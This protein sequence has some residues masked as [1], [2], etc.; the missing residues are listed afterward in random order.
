LNSEDWETI[1]GYDE[2]VFARTTPEPISQLFDGIWLGLSVINANLASDSS[3]RQAEVA[4]NLLEG[5]NL[6]SLNSEDWETICG[7]DEIVFAR[8]TPEQKEDQ[9]GCLDCYVAAGSDCNAHVCC[10][11]GWGIVDATYSQQVVGPR[12]GPFS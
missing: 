12:S 4:G 10:A 3:R 9:I 1:C 5:P 7:Y 11:Q 6:S 2:I 8:T